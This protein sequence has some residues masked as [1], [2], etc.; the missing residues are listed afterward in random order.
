MG[1][2]ATDI[3]NCLINIP[4]SWS[5]WNSWTT[6]SL[7]CGTGNQTRAATCVGGC[8][9]ADCTPGATTS[10]SQSCQLTPAGYWTEWTSWSVCSANCGNGTQSRTVTCLGDCPSTNCTPGQVHN[11][12]QDCQVTTPG[13]WA[14][15]G[16]WGPCS[17]NCGEG[18]QL[19]NASCV[20]CPSST[21]NF[22]TFQNATQSC[23][24]GPAAVWGE[25]APSTCDQTSTTRTWVRSCVPN[26]YGTCNG[27]DAEPR[28]CTWDTIQLWAGPLTVST[29]VPMN[30]TVAEAITAVLS[31]ALQ[32]LDPVRFGQVTPININITATNRRRSTFNQT[33][34][35]EPGPS[36][37]TTFMACNIQIYNQS[38][39]T[40]AQRA[41]QLQVNISAI[42]PS[43]GTTIT[44]YASVPQIQPS[45]KNSSTTGSTNSGAI[46]GAVLAVVLCFIVVIVILL[47]R[48]RRY[49]K[50]TTM[51][52]HT[53]S[54]PNG[55]QLFI[56]DNPVFSG[57]VPVSTKSAPYPN[58]VSPDGYNI[59]SYDHDETTADFLTSSASIA[60]NEL[61]VPRSGP[62]YANKVAPADHD[63]PP[64]YNA[65][66]NGTSPVTSAYGATSSNSE[67]NSTYGPTNREILGDASAEE[68]FAILS[69]SAQLK[70][71]Y[72]GRAPL[73]S[74]VC[75]LP[76]PLP[77]KGKSVNHDVNYYGATN[78]LGGIAAQVITSG[79]GSLNHNHEDDGPPLPPK[80]SEY[81]GL[82]PH[83]QKGYGQLV[84]GKSPTKT[85]TN[86]VPGYG[87]LASR[88][89]HYD[90]AVT[91]STSLV[92]GDTVTCGNTDDDY[93]TPPSLLNGQSTPGAA[94]AAAV[95][96]FD[97]SNPP[98]ST[99]LITT[100]GRYDAAENWLQNNGN[101]SVV[102]EAPYVAGGHPNIIDRGSQQDVT[103][104]QVTMFL[105][106]LVGCAVSMSSARAVTLVKEEGE[107]TG[108]YVVRQSSSQKGFVLTF[109]HAGQAMHERIEVDDGVT[110]CGRSFAGLLDMLQVQQRK[111]VGGTGTPL[112][113]C[114]PTIVK[115]VKK[116]LKSM[117]QPDLVSAEGDVVAQHVT[118]L[119]VKALADYVMA[120]D[121]AAKAL[122]LSPATLPMTLDS[123]IEVFFG[124]TDEDE[125]GTTMV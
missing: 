75:D 76:P 18:V 23:S 46:I 17:S 106:T 41:E 83:G 42:T 59:A 70:G 20:G 74:S 54:Y 39:A 87:A 71:G 56:V 14:P 105:Q 124:L 58:L 53:N 79:Y 112:M 16:P 4:G 5:P 49:T 38:Q 40:A 25:W 35:I 115:G 15:W 86:S 27:S 12:T 93:G 121:H 51:T 37:N 9:Y 68:Q 110:L 69:T 122:H 103:A 29:L 109:W 91:D 48:R 117:R 1:Q 19:R 22:G 96:Y 43:M 65:L 34:Q 28:S 104:A 113:R 89:P 108:T 95:E 63:P 2:N 97:V 30:F 36:A 13:Y 100:C 73:T 64:A 45:I 125:K 26:C 67:I 116:V 81:D 61:I 57:T 118:M 92:Y 44:F 84:R 82:S 8:S 24:G 85:M 111:S 88:P 3:Q 47:H 80:R 7:S 50:S 107:Q 55:T 32:N 52:N 90:Y 31:T 21:C 6:C 10:Q 66:A 119:Q 120:D 123:L 62:H 102:D 11:Q 98:L 78:E 77:P 99:S 101:A 33:L 60:M 94:G 114:S 72:D